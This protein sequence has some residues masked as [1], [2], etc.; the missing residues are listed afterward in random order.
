FLM[1][2]NAQFVGF[3]LEIGPDGALYVL[4][5]HDADICGQEVLH[6][7]TGRIF[8]VAPRTSHA[9]TFEGRYTDLRTLSDAQ[10]VD[11]QTR[12]SAWHARRARVFLQHRAAT[13]TLQ[14]DT[15]ERLRVMFR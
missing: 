9:E 1:A 13:G 8:R 14:A 7:E 3:S 2:N 11:L 15:H 10:L 6:K 4:D 12:R 5:W